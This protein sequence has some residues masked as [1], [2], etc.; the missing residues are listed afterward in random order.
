MPTCPVSCYL[1]S[2]NALAAG[3]SGR[4]GRDITC[5]TCGRYVVGSDPAAQLAPHSEE[6]LRILSAL[7]RGRQPGQPLELNGDTIP[8]VIATFQY[9]RAALARYGL[10][11]AEL[12]FLSAVEYASPLYSVEAAG[13]RF[14]LRVFGNDHFGFDGVRSELHWLLW[15]R[16]FG[17]RVMEPISA[18]DGALVQEIHLRG[19]LEPRRCALYS[20]VPGTPVDGIRVEDETEA[21]WED[22]GAFLGRMHEAAARFE[23]PEWFARPRFGRD[24]ISDSLQAALRDP[25]LSEGNRSEMGA[26]GEAYLAELDLLGCG[27]DTFGMVHNDLSKS[28]LLFDGE[29]PGLIDFYES[30]WGHYLPAIAAALTMSVDRRSEGAGTALLRGYESA[31]P[32]PERLEERVALVR[33]AWKIPRRRDTWNWDTP[34]NTDWW[35]WM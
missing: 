29:T 9:A 27:R 6:D 5:P 4:A 12:A 30:A 18:D 25:E 15:L 3:D 2:G 17:L 32:L 10:G 1:C 34:R 16:S 35:T 31:R 23:P 28:N 24:E 11:H 8:K 20:W 7:T 13:Q 21:M 22:Y 14:S 33:R 19:D 26:V